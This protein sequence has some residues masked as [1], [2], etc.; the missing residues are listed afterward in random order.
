VCLAPEV[1]QQGSATNNACWVAGGA[2]SRRMP[3]FYA[4]CTL[5]AS[6]WLLEQC[7]SPTSRGQELWPRTNSACWVAGSAQ[8]RRNSA[9]QLLLAAPCTQVV[10]CLS[11]VAPLPAG[12][13]SCG[14]VPCLLGGQQRTGRGACQHVVLASLAA[15]DT[16]PCVHTGH[17]LCA[18][19]AVCTG[20]WV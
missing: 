4:G 7:C 19:G 10:G 8:S 12:V 1:Y 17:V 15:F 20:T 6:G 16:N 13:R 5:H 14:L 2:Q 18:Q 3:A 11:S 9:A